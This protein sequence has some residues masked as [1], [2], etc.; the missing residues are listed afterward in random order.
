MFPLVSTVAEFERAGA[1]L[2]DVA[3]EEGIDLAG[4]EVGV[5]IEVPSAALG[6]ARLAARADFLSIGT[7]DLL[8]YLLAADRLNAAVA[9][10]ADVYEPDA[11]ALV[12]QIIDAGHA[13]GTRVGL[14][15]EAA[16]DPLLAAALVGLGIDELSMASVA[17]PEVRDV[18]SRLELRQCEDA[19]RHALERGTDGAGVRRLLE[20]HLHL[21]DR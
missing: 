5:M 14:C 19:V 16:S 8:Q 4:L 1:A 13:H 17:I 3:A 18:L 12:G 2:V 21:D 7:N 11:L 15:G 6:A 20:E 9:G 10:L